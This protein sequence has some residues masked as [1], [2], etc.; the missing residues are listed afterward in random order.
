M[1]EPAI[2]SSHLLQHI[3]GVA[4][5]LL[6]NACASL[7]ESECRAGDWRAIGYRD[8]QNGRSFGRI[9]DHRNACAEF[10]VVPNVTLYREGHARGLLFYCT[11]TNGLAVGRRGDT[12]LGVCPPDLEPSF[13]RYYASGHD[14]YEARQRLDRLDD[15]QRSLEERIRKADKRDDPRYLEDERHRL[16]RERDLAW[17]ELQ[18]REDWANRMRY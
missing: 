7:T 14:I 16:H 12:Y 10:G 18:R 11:P 15:E 1:P 9:E 5:L 8:G 13:L 6:L 4:V 17:E 2:P 3:A